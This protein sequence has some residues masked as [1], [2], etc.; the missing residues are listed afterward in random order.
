YRRVLTPRVGLMRTRRAG[1]NAR[2]GFLELKR[3]NE[4]AQRAI[5]ARDDMLAMVSHDLKASL[6]TLDLHID[7]LLAGSPARERRAVGRARLE[8]AQRAIHRMKR[9]VGDLLDASRLDAGQFRLRPG[10]H[11][12]G[13]LVTESLEP[14]QPTIRDKSIKLDLAIDDHCRCA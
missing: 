10:E 11:D 5:R 2:A 1:R 6:H 13:S 9:L 14:F 4:L 3:Q 8:A 12:V 7:A